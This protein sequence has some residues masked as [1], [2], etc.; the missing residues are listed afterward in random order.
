MWKM[1]TF[2]FYHLYISYIHLDFSIINTII[3]LYFFLVSMLWKAVI[4]CSPLI[5]RG[6]DSLSLRWKDLNTQVI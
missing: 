6:G 5:I 2:I 4:L 3:K 1:L